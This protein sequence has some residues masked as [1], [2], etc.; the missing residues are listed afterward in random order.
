[1]TTAPQAKAVVGRR[2]SRREKCGV[3]RA[4]HGNAPISIST[5]PGSG[6][7]VTAANAAT[8][9]AAPAAYGGTMR[10]CACSRRNRKRAPLDAACHRAVHDHCGGHRQQQDQHPHQYEAA[11]HA[12]DARQDGG[13][14]YRDEYDGPDDHRPVRK[15]PLTSA[16]MRRLAGRRHPP[17]AQ[18]RGRGR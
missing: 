11:G 7:S 12:E 8:T 3:A 16:S 1:M 17:E 18:W 14:E 10:H 15:D 13:P 9:S 4:S 2:M 5:T 6:T